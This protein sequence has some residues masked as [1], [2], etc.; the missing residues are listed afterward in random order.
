MGEDIDV[1]AIYERFRQKHSLPSYDKLDHEF[2]ISEIDS[3]EHFLEQVRHCICDKLSDVLSIFEDIFS[4]DTNIARM[5]ENQNFSIAEKESAFSLYRRLMYFRR[6]GDE[7][8]VK[9]GDEAHA[10]FIRQI[11]AEWPGLKEQIGVILAKLKEFWVKANGEQTK[12]EYFV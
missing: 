7:L 2:H 3:E 11:T 9:D 6:Y 4:T 10:E 1:K 8:Y 12:V 5:Y